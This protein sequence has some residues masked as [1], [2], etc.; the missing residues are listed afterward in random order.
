M[1]TEI[2]NTWEEEWKS[3]PNAWKVLELNRV[4]ESRDWVYFIRI[5]ER[6]ITMIRIDRDTILEMD[7]GVDKEIR[8]LEKVKSGSE[9]VLNIKKALQ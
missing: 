7:K 3:I 4:G 8:F 9:N 1:K 6:S 5:E 2:F